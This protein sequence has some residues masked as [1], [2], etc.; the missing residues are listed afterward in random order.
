MVKLAL[1]Q[2]IEPLTVIH[3][4]QYW[5]YRGPLHAQEIGVTVDYSHRYCQLD[6][7][8]CTTNEKRPF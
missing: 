4:R 2:L 8:V 6:Y 7:W 3:E 5:E 1:S